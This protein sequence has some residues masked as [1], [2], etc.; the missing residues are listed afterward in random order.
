MPI[1]GK[2]I[3]ISPEHRLRNMEFN[4]EAYI[5]AD[6][7]VITEK[8]V[9]IDLDALITYKSEIEGNEYYYVHSGLALIKRI[10][11]GGGLTE[12]D[13]EIN[14]NTEEMKGYVFTMANSHRYYDLMSNIENYILFTEFELCKK[15]N[16][17][18][19]AITEEETE[20]S[21]ELKLRDAIAAQDFG[22][23]LAIQKALSERQN[24]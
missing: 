9:F 5:D 4:K 10:G 15:T 18:E 3:A 20:E 14:L 6:Y 17:L 19:K 13:F 24:K 1:K 23:V 12:D 2:I 22:T 7:L 8:G 16:H 21:L 11:V